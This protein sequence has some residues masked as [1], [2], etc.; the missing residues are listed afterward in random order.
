MEVDD[1]H[2]PSLQEWEVSADYS[3][4]TLAEDS[5]GRLLDTRA[6]GQ[7][8]RRLPS[9][10]TGG[11]A[12]RRGMIRY[13]YVILDMSRAMDQTDGDFRP[14]RA[15]VTRQAT[16]QFIL[17]YFAHNPISQLG[18]I[19][20][21]NA[22]AE[23]ITELSGNQRA[24]IEALGNDNRLVPAGD[25]SLQNAL[26]MACSL[27]RDIPEYG[28]REVLVIYGSLASRDP[29]DIFAT[30][31]KLRKHHVRVSVVGLAAEVDVLRTLV[32]R[33]GGTLGVARNV[34]HFK[35]LLRGHS[36][37]P[38]PYDEERGSLRAEMVEM[39]FPQREQAAAGSLGYNDAH[40]EFLANCYICPRC[41][42]R[43]AEI[44]SVCIVCTLPL[45][46]ASL[47]AQSNHHLF[48][49][50]A[51]REVHTFRPDI[52]KEGEAGDGND[53][54]DL[55]LRC[56]GCGTYERR[57]AQMYQCPNCHSHYC[58]DCDTLLHDLIHNCPTCL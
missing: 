30:M 38:P 24:H 25:A 47:L 44:P 6:A 9:S 39:G 52:S 32:D 28:F 43:T 26:D 13:L 35:E 15:Q 3:F 1:S 57:R 19:I 56:C 48:P 31:Q 54:D 49:L 46:S 33:T 21:R 17:D 20:T 5:K 4:S 16:K 42:T 41:K 10:I 55:R 36:H 23:K 27:L 50:S 7:V 51:F 8:R 18:V 14:K 53:D 45:V 29:G 34:G 58:S 40:L 22:Q 2:G 12:I 11:E 37:E